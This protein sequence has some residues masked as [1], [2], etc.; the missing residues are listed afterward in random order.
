MVIEVHCPA[1]GRFHS[2]HHAHRCTAPVT[3]RRECQRTDWCGPGTHCLCVPD[4]HTR[5]HQ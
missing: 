4:A 2:P 5:Q 1:C 3:D